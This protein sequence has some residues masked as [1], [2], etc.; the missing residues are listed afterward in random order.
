M[1]NH[2]EF[3]VV[4]RNVPLIDE[5]Q[6]DTA[7]MKLRH[8]VIMVD[9]LTKFDYRIIQWTIERTPSQNNGVIKYLPQ[10]SWQI[11]LLLCAVM[12]DPKPHICLEA[13]LYSPK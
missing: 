9:I 8:R 3:E 13:L 11:L 12:Q 5:S 2:D 10:G 7:P 1:R 4:E 6:N